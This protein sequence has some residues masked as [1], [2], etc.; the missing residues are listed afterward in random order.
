MRSRAPIGSLIPE[1]ALFDDEHEVHRILESSLVPRRTTLV[2]VGF[3][4]WVLVVAFLSRA[5]G[6]SL[7][8]SPWVAQAAIQPVAMLAGFYW[9]FNS[10]LR[11]PFQRALREALQR[12]GV[13][14]C[15][16]N[17]RSTNKTAATEDDVCRNDVS[18]HC[19]PWPNNRQVTQMIAWIIPE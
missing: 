6:A 15:I 1:T 18:F 9:L 11:K 4:A 13:A 7:G 3:V 16:G 5:A 19:F 8:L 12:K 10:G 17:G 2:I 14:I